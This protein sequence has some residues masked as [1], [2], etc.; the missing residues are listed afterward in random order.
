MKLILLSILWVLPLA[1]DWQRLVLTGKGE[2]FDTPQPHSLSYFTQYPSLRDEDGDFCSGC[3]PEKRLALAK[4]QKERAQVRLAGIVRGFAIYDV[5]YF[6]GE[7]KK[8]G[9]KSILIRTQPGQYREIFHYQRNEGGIWPSYLVKAGTETLLG[10]QDDCYKQQTIQEYYWFGGAAPAR[11]DFK[12]IWKAA[13]AAAPKGT[14]AWTGYDGRID[15]P[16]G[17]FR[18]GLIADPA[19][20]C[21]T[22][23]VVEVGFKL[24]G[25]RVVVTRARLDREAK[26]VWGAGCR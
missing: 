22:A 13:E 9:W 14:V 11:I 7:D 2:R 4:Q 24:E 23:G 20:R 3:A 16:A 8:A 21:C 5:L 6:F 26:F 25:G 18:V 12:P 15:L 17:Q 10:L 1:A 19:W